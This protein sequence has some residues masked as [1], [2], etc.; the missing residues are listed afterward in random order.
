MVP[1]ARSV[2][3]SAGRRS[4]LVKPEERLPLIFLGAGTVVI[5][6][7]LALAAV[8]PYGPSPASLGEVTL[9]AASLAAAA[10]SLWSLAIDRGAWRGTVWAARAATGAV[11]FQFVAWLNRFWDGSPAEG[12]IASGTMLFL[13]A[14][15]LAAMVVDFLQHVTTG[16]LDV[17][18]DAGVVAVLA[19]GGV[20]LLQHGQHASAGTTALSAAVAVEVI[21]AFAGWAALSLW[22]PSAVHLSLFACATLAGG[23]AL[24]AD[25]ISR[26]AAS[27]DTLMA[28]EVGGALSILA[29]TGILVVEPRLVDRGQTARPRAVW[30]VRPILLSL[31]L[32]GAF[33]LVAVALLGRNAKLSVG[34]SLVLAS[35]MF[36]AVGI[37]SLVSQFGMARATTLMGASLKEREAALSSLRDA[38]QVVSSSEARH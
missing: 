28:P 17:L 36:A 12:R 38:A 8:V 21:V 33:V 15:F 19:A 4:P 20:F 26:S 29:L 27:L 2:D 14:I 31:S 35:G 6:V 3:V 9:L 11:A 1:D 10:A 25:H 22:C 7:L 24:I 13:L 37:R 34:Q 32:C 5:F 23:A 30:W 16:R 18:S